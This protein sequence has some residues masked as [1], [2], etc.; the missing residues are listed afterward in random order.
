MMEFIIP[1]HSRKLQ[2]KQFCMGIF[3]HIIGSV[4]IIHKIWTVKIF[5]VNALSHQQ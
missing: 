1:T 4:Q 3:T 5:D 2:L